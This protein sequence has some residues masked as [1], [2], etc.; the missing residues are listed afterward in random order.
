MVSRRGYSL[1]SQM[2]HE[3]GTSHECAPISP[4]GLFPL[5][6]L[7]DDVTTSFCVSDEMDDPGQSNSLAS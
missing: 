3:D 7:A 4:T 5:T 2:T 6:L 1:Y